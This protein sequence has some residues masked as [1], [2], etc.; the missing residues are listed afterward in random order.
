M[1]ANWWIDKT[2]QDDIDRGLDWAKKVDREKL[3]GFSVMDEPGRN[4]PDTP[5]GFYIDLYEKLKPEFRA[6]FPN[7]RLEISHWGPMASWDDRYYDYFSYLYEAA[8]VMRIMP[9][10]DLYEGP[11][12]DVFFMIQR[13][14]RMMEIAQRELPLVVIL[15]AWLLP[16]DGKLPT[17]SEL[18]VMAYQAMLSGAETVSFFEYNEEIWAKT[19]GFKER[20]RELMKEVTEQPISK[21]QG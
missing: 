1:L 20:F 13:S 9:Y 11:L 2:K 10:P 5:F 16:P 15:Q 8:D 4:A 12:D 14:R 18:R 3:V 17:I 21:L 6:D 19:P 7:T